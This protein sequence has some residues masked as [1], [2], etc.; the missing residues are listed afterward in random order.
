[1]AGIIIEGVC[2]SGKSTIMKRIAKRDWY[3]EKQNKIQF[4]EYLTE[5]IVENIGPSVDNRVELL[6]GYVDILEKVYYN[7]YNS[8]FANT[9]S[10]RVKPFFLIERFHM[11]HGLES[12]DFNPFKDIDN[13]LAAMDMKLVLLVMDD[14]VIEKR[15]L[16]TFPR[17]P[18]T[19]ENYCLSFGGIKGAVERYRNMQEMLLS[20]AK[21]TKLDTII[22][23]TSQEDWNV[24]VDI[25]ESH[26][27]LH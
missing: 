14:N 13:R 24:Y 23:N 17:R 9:K 16:D 22:L 20:F 21:L 4:G 8:R 2:A 18:K 5:R 1:M 25:I 6:E 11:T 27:N 19:W 12:K 7:F 3:V 15:L 10:E 26:M